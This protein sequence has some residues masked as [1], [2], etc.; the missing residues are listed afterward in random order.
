MRIRE[1]HI[2]ILLTLLWTLNGVDK[3]FVAAVN[4]GDVVNVVDVF[5]VDVFVVDVF[6][7]VIFI[8]VVAIDVG[9]LVLIVD[10][11]DFVAGCWE[12]VN[13]EDAVTGGLL[14]ADIQGDV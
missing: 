9:I 3:F 14:R 4:T 7:V 10:V 1:R 8:V 13:P 12:V 6:V 11:I 2:S 5:A